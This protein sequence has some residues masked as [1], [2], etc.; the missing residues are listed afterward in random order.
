IM[1]PAA[2]GVAAA[3]V[4]AAGAGAGDAAGD[5]TTAGVD[6]DSVELL[7]VVSQP[8]T[9]ATTQAAAQTQRA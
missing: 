7:L 9:N 3:G 6:E 4:A 1:P 8:V 2:V 5:S